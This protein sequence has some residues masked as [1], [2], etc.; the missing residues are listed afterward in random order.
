MIELSRSRTVAAPAAAVWALLSD[1]GGLARWAAGVDHSC[2]L[3]EG[4]DPPHV[5]SARRVQIG[6]NAVLETISEYAPPLVLGYTINGVPQG[7]SATNTWVLQPRHSTTLV[8]LSSAV[9]APAPV[10]RPV[11]ERVVAR[12]LAR[13]SEKLL[14]SLAQATERIPS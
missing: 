13:R 4:D 2:V 3:R 1:F 10:I 8:T 12:L 6:R 9:C 11:A 14:R 5:G 7:F